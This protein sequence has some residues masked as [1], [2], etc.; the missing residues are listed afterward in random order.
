MELSADF[1]PR[2]HYKPVI[3]D[4]EMNDAER[5]AAGLLSSDDIALDL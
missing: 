4:G 2:Q 3:D 5:V 1:D